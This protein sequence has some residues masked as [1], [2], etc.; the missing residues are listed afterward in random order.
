MHLLLIKLQIQLFPHMYSYHRLA[1]H[2]AA[3]YI[4]LGRHVAV[5][6]ILHILTYVYIYMYITIYI[7]IHVIRYPI[8]CYCYTIHLKQGGDHEVGVFLHTANHLHINSISLI[9]VH[10]LFH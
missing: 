8:L 3:I 5:V 7:I 4:Q 1:I 10:A 6:D 2:I 9:T